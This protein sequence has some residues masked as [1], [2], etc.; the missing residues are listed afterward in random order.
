MEKLYHSLFPPMVSLSLIF[1]NTLPREMLLASLTQP[2]GFWLEIVSNFEMAINLSLAILR[3]FCCWKVNI[4]HYG[5]RI[6]N[7]NNL[8]SL[9]CWHSWK[10]KGV[11]ANPLKFLHFNNLKSNEICSDL[12]TES[13]MAASCQYLRKMLKPTYSISA[14]FEL[15]EWEMWC[16]IQSTHIILQPDIFFAEGCFLL[17]NLKLVNTLAQTSPKWLCLASSGIMH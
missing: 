9:S 15:T 4:T 17:F 16:H 1:F 7:L 14:H 2:S 10:A 8:F 12:V 11:K 13:T 6:K 3:V 5:A